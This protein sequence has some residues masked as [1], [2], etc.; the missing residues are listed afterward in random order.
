MNQ[1]SPTYRYPVAAEKR[2]SP[3]WRGRRV[4]GAQFL[5]GWKKKKARKRRNTHTHIIQQYEGN[6]IFHSA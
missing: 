1:P 5:V 4:K 3:G 2:P 6:I